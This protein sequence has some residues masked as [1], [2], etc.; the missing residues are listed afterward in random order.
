MP[1]GEATY[2]RVA[3]EDPDGEW[4]LDCGRLWSKPGMTTQHND[5]SKTVYQGEGI[6]PS[7]LPSVVIDLDE[8]FAL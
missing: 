6:R 5:V 4:E 8:L 7:A 2:E 1:V 3:L